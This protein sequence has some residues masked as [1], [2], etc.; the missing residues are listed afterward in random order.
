[1]GASPDLEGG[2][3]EVFS[4]PP[5][6]CS[7]PLSPSQDTETCAT[8]VWCHYVCYPYLSLGGGPL[9]PKQRRDLGVCLCVFFFFFS[10][11]WGGGGGGGGYPLLTSECPLEC[12]YFLF[13]FCSV[14]RTE[15][16]LGV[17][18]AVITM[19]AFTHYR[20]FACRS[21]AT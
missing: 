3:S 7:R 13:C 20:S 21:P 19:A 15:H 1:M 16:C 9:A 14:D 17:L 6:H 2:C 5:L 11:F 18:D 8:L 10:F 12:N 4:G